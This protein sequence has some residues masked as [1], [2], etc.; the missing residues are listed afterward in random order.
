M[1]FFLYSSLFNSFLWTEYKNKMKKLYVQAC[2]IPI[3]K[4]GWHNNFWNTHIFLSL[5]VRN[6]HRIEGSEAACRILLVSKYSVYSL[7]CYFLRHI[8]HMGS[9]VIESFM[10]YIF[11]VEW[12]YPRGTGWLWGNVGNQEG[13]KRHFIMYL[14]NSFRWSI[15]YYIHWIEVHVKDYHHHPRV[16]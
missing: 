7:H 9:F 1:L 16:I 3:Q 13:N 14:I 12:L 11:W 10:Y 8:V 6:G 2:L 4:S 15:V 5:R